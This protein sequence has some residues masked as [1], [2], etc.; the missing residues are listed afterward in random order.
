MRGWWM[1]VL[2][3]LTVALVAATGAQAADPLPSSYDLV[4]QAR[5]A[6]KLRP[7]RAALLGLQALAAP[8]RVPKAYRGHGDVDPAEVMADVAAALP[9][10]SA[11]ERRAVKPY[12]LPPIFRQSAWLPARLRA[13]KALRTASIAR[14]PSNGC[15]DYGSIVTG[16]W[17]SVRAGPTAIVY[18]PADRHGYRASAV[19][20]AHELS[21]KVL[22]TLT[23][24]F[25]RPLATIRS[26][27]DELG[28][29]ELQYYVVAPTV[30]RDSTDGHALAVTPALSKESHGCDATASFVLLPPG[31]DRSVVAHET[32]H[33]VQFAYPRCESQAALIEGGAV[34]AE[35]LVYPGT[36]SKRAYAGSIATPFVGLLDS[37][38]SNAYN[39]W[40]FWYALGRPAGAAPAARAAV[41]KRI[42]EALGQPGATLAS[43]VAAIV[44]GGWRGAFSA[45]ALQRWNQEPVGVSGSPVKE[46]FKAWD[47][48]TATPGGVA[49]T[50]V[51]LGGKPQFQTSYTTSTRQPLSTWFQDL[52]IKRSEGAAGGRHASRE[53]PTS[54][55]RSCKLADGTWRVED[56]SGRGE[57]RLC[58]D[59]ANEN[60]T[61]IVVATTNAL[62][63]GAGLGRGGVQGHGQGPLRRAAGLPRHVHTERHPRPD[64]Q[65]HRRVQAEARAADRCGWA[66]DVRPHVGLGAVEHVLRLHP[67]VPDH[68][69]GDR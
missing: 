52:A 41:M 15:D 57:V 16:A 20:Y 54:S 65:R 66:L 48:W 31:A 11:A 4:Q 2:L 40:A 36:P 27:C 45:Y 63:T 24:L 7:G 5:D 28:G 56:W 61:R 23:R 10:M 51:A 62:P 47:R 43:V 34:L 22:P 60:V 3:A 12:L 14:K 30:I 46:S 18:Y 39:A 35:D 58:R 9:R 42:L 64:D 53:R 68:R 21:T 17:Q 13:R 44:P 32:M 29:D 19:R 37:T 49:K 69:V 1:T 59:R 26:G 50:D 33:A 67:G 55:R 6:G 8:K 25:R 38:G